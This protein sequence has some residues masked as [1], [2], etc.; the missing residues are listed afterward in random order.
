M[1]EYTNEFR[2]MRVFEFQV[3]RQDGTTRQVVAFDNGEGLREQLE[4]ILG[5]QTI[6]ECR[7]RNVGLLLGNTE[8]GMVL[9]NHDPSGQ[10]ST[11]ILRILN[12]TG[13]RGQLIFLCDNGTIPL[14]AARRLKKLALDFDL[15]ALSVTSLFQ[16]VTEADNK[17]EPKI[18]S[19]AVG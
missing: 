5:S 15:G 18:M 8:S 2:N 10:V 3:S 1:S 11:E 14:H 12:Q 16:K 17:L 4:N 6:K 13:F 7:P 19:S 9:A